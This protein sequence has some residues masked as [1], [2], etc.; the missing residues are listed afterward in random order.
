MRARRRARARAG[1][2]RARSARRRA[3]VC[4]APHLRARLAARLGVGL[5]RALFGAR[6]VGGALACTLIAAFAESAARSCARC[7]AES[8]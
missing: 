5:T 8:F 1:D 2:A 4:A 6:L 7:L 3:S